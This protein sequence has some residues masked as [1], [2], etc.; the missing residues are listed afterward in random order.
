MKSDS[1]PTAVTNPVDSIMSEQPDTVE[2]TVV[3]YGMLL[4]DAIVPGQNDSISEKSDGG[5]S[6]VFLVLGILFVIVAMKFRNNTRYLRALV[7]DL[8]DVR[9]RHNAFDDTVRE[10][11]FLLLLN[12][13]WVCCAGVLLWQLLNVTGMYHPSSPDETPYRTAI[14]ISICTGVCVAYSLVMSLAY[15]LIGNV[16]TDRVKTGMWLKGWAASQGLQVLLLFPLTL[17]SLCNPAWVVYVLEISAI[18]FLVGKIV[19]IYKGFRIFFNQ[20]SSWM[21]FLYY[22]CSLEI[23]PLILAYLSGAAMCDR[24]M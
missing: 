8:T 17:L 13:M 9:E 12:L 21:L 24:L 4:Q 20:I 7:M 16:F 18:V 23:V 22:L 11:S 19:F 10:T 2:N 1:I 6:W 14:G 5:T 15:W 3:H